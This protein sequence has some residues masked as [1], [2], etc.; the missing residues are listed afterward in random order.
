MIKIFPADTQW[1]IAGTVPTSSLEQLARQLPQEL[2][3]DGSRVVGG[4]QGF[5]ALLVF[6]DAPNE[7]LAKRLLT[8]VTPVYLLDFDDEAPVVVRL[9][10]KNTR[11]TESRLDEHPAE[12]LEDRGIEAPGY[13]LTPSPIDAVGLVE[14]TTPEEAKRAVPDAEV[15]F[16]K[17]P[18]GVLVLDDQ[19]G[20]VPGVL[21]QS[22]K[23]RAYMLLRNREDGWFCC[24]V[25]EPG[26]AAASYSPA[27]PDPNRPQLDNVLGE[28]TLEGIVR[29]LEIPGELLG[30]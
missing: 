1:A 10:R 8:S 9:D 16:R 29:V 24:V 2:Q 7:M 30:L 4:P 27:R 14:D 19:W 20:M 5:S 11:V 3:G 21:S 18:R 12:F 17:H 15:E 25:S 6:G 26:K 13:T 22:L 23:R 28:T